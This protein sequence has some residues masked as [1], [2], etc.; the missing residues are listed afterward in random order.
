MNESQRRVADLLIVDARLDDYV[1][2]VGQLEWLD[3]QATLFST[4]EEAL[5]ANRVAQ[6]SLWIINV[7]LPDMSGVNLLEHIRRR[8]R[9]SNIFLV[10]DAYSAADE[11]AARA[12]GATAYFC[13]PPTAAWL[14]ACQAH[15]YALG[16]SPPFL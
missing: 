7:R 4:G 10:G 1:T 5:R 6:S 3:A 12:A 16:A 8:S 15:S 13:K 2:L 9:R 11:L 14:E